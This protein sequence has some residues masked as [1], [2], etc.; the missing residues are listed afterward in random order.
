LGA[1]GAEVVRNLKTV[2]L[3]GQGLEC[4]PSWVSWLS[5][6][7]TLM[8]DGNPLSFIPDS[9]KRNGCKAILSYVRDLQGGGKAQWNRAKIMVLGKEC[10]GKSLVS[11]NTGK[12]KIQPECLNKWD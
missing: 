5:E 3:V 12:H 4:L 11:K 2:K 9:V 10:V 1:R 6:D 7:V 8:L